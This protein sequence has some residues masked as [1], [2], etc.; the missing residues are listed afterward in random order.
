[1][2]WNTHLCWYEHL[3]GVRFSDSRRVFVSA[4]VL[5]C[6]GHSVVGA[7]IVTG[8]SANPV[9]GPAETLAQQTETPVN[10][11]TVQQEDPDEV[12]EQGD[13]DALRSYLAQK[14]ADRLGESS[15]QISQGQYEQGQ[16]VL[17]DEYD[18]LLEKY[19]DVEGGTDDDSAADSF[20]EASENQREFGS[21]VEE[22]NETY[23]EYREAKEAGNSR[24]ARELA[25]ELDR[26]E[27]R[28]DSSGQNLT[29]SYT[30]IENTTG[31]DLTDA[32]ENIENISSAIQQQQAE[33]VATTF[34]ETT[35]SVRTDATTV[36]F[37]DP[38]EI[39]GQLVLE[40]GTVLSNE[41][42]EISIGM[43][44]ETVQTDSEG[45]FAISFQPV[46][47][48]AGEKTVSVAYRPAASSI[49]LRSSAS[50]EIDVTQVTANVSVSSN[51][52]TVRFGDELTVT[53]RAEVNGSPV[54]GARVQ[55]SV[56]RRVLGTAVTGPNGT[57]RLTTAFPASIPNGMTTVDSAIVPSDRAV[58]SDPVTTNLQVEQ[59]QTA[60]S[61]D[62]T[63]TGASEV[64][65]SGQLQT[66]DGRSV[67][68]QT[69]ELRIAG[70]TVATVEI[71]ADGT[72]QRT[73]SLNEGLV[74]EVTVRAVY[75]EPGSNLESATAQT[76]L[77]LRS[78]DGFDSENG[79]GTGSRQ[80]DGLPMVYEQLPGDGTFPFSLEQLAGSVVVVLALLVL[81][82]VVRRD[83]EPL[84]PE[85]PTVVSDSP[86]PNE[87]EP[88]PDI[89]EQASSLLS[90][91]DSEAA[92]RTLYAAVRE[93][94]SA[95]DDSTRTHWEF[96]TAASNRLDT[97]AV[98]ALEQ[99]TEA[100]ERVVYSAE[101][102][103]ADV[104]EQLLDESDQFIG[105]HS[106]EVS[107]AD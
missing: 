63:Q 83:E 38:A 30:N 25:R 64:K 51:P 48:Q 76:R 14:L 5:L 42:I 1:M 35:L 24:R 98:G 99:L 11:T 73:V 49:Y 31:T 107:N 80:Q 101:S 34:V 67:S 53:G 68:G 55:V 4:V 23:Q 97:D 74:G 78:S 39:Y 29:R 36:S 100:Y 84:E 17:G 56:G 87:S 106:T 44:T 62:A 103:D 45:K 57:Y 32:R 70:S 94:I 18:D 90:A 2:R 21:A 96:Y 10:N 15:I 37:E 27:D 9:S 79:S 91:G 95:D 93:S 92:I 3:A 104:A 7:G 72:Y 75:D 85:Q 28:L 43:R 71:R 41:T 77:Q 60:L 8:V 6:L 46:T 52:S 33:I 19:V 16:S 47:L 65:L 54:L 50:L 12:N 66:A 105:E 13:S 89:L 26:I 102:V 20:D 59:T 61:V 88:D 22:Y 69:I 58:H 40:N 82:W 81:A 86:P